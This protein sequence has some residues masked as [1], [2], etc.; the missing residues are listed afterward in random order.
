VKV[1]NGAE[2]EGMRLGG[3]AFYLSVAKRAPTVVVEAQA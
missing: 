1:T 3:A 2:V